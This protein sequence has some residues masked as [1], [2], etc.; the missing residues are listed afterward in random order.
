LRGLKLSRDELCHGVK[1]RLHNPL[2]AAGVLFI[3]SID[4]LSRLLI[5]IHQ[6]AGKG[7]IVIVPSQRTLMINIEAA[8]QIAKS[9]LGIPLLVKV[10]TLSIGHDFSAMETAAI[11]RPSQ[12]SKKRRFA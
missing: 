5:V 9:Q 3:F 6:Y 11:F 4:F 8:A 1:V 2:P 12:I 7:Q 10:G